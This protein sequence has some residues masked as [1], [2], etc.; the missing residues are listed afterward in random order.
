MFDNIKGKVLLDSSLAPFTTW[1][2]GG[3]CRAIVFPKDVEDIQRVLEICRKNHIPF[4]TMG[5]GSNLLKKDTFYN[6]IVI[7]M[8][9]ALNS[10]KIEEDRIV[11]G[12][13]CMLPQLAFHLAHH[14]VGNF[15]FYA[16]IPGT[17]GGAVVMNAGSAGK[18]TKDIILAV[19]YIN[20]DGE[21]IRET[22]DNLEFGYRK[23]KF[24]N[25]NTVILSAEFK[26][27]YLDRN[28]AMN[29]TK[30][31]VERR[32]KKFPLKLPT[33]GSTFKSPVGGPYPG[34]IIEEL[35]LKGM[36]KGGARI[37]KLHGNWIE[38]FNHAS[39]SDINYLIEYAQ[40]TV[41]EK[42]GIK[43]ELEVVKL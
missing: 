36:V 38:N 19:T 32:R 27:E 13:G 6:G 33:A 23:S 8:S 14:S 30:A 25:K 5:N 29:R 31:I 7:N 28:I 11:V 40:N 20:E 35:G 42:K 15:D 22:A 17:V 34:Q 16:G 43:L 12:S 3:N 2:V 18:E 24:Q 41:E 10:I 39:Y 37:S 21:I 1:K 26:K 9:R 4:F